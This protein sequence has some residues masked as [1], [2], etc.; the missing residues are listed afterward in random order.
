LIK[1]IVIKKN[2]VTTFMELEKNMLLRKKTC[3]LKKKKR[4]ALKKKL[5]TSGEN[6]P[7]DDNCP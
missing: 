2:K 6:A 1:K 7:K 5:G 3:V 4:W